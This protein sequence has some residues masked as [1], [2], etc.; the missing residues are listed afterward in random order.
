[1]L[2]ANK[3][4]KQLN[5]INLTYSVGLK[6]FENICYFSQ[7]NYAALK[8]VPSPFV[9]LVVFQ[10]INEMKSEDPFFALFLFFLHRI[11]LQYFP[12][13]CN[14]QGEIGIQFTSDFKQ[15]SYIS[16]YNHNFYSESHFQ[17]PFGRT[18]D[19][20]S[21]FAGIG[22]EQDEIKPFLFLLLFF[23]FLMKT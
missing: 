15:F 13:F 7:R 17:Q 20:L 11:Q 9:A 1:M 3:V 16:Y 14:Q 21:K 19:T 4:D 10:Q 12:P 18:L 23:L 5:R 22:Y 8:K 6:A 2:A